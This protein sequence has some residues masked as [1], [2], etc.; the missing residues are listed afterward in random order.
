MGT[1]SISDVEGVVTGWSMAFRGF[2]SDIFGLFSQA[3]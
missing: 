3:V 1:F 2:F